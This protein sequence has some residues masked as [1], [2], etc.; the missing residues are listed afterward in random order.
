MLA[1]YALVFGLGL[2]PSVAWLIFFD[3]EESK[4][5]AP[6]ID[7]LYAF[8]LGSLTTFA[9]LVV[10]LGIARVMPVIGITPH[11]GYGVTIFAAVEEVLKFAAV[12]FLISRRRSFNEPLDAMVYLITVALGFAAVE[13]IASLINQ[14]G[15]GAAAMSARSIELVVLRFLGATLLH[16]VT[17]AVV[18]FHWAVGWVR[19]RL[20]WFHIFAGLVIASALHAIFNYLILTTGPAS[21]ALAFVAAIAFFVLVDFEELRTEE[22]AE[23]AAGVIFN[24]P[25]RD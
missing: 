21:W 5:Y 25:P 12:Y 11:D 14:G 16:S 19:K 6:F 7:L 13:N 22:E 15:L 23:E 1:Q 10:Q 18:G 24:G 2:L 3:L 17:S 9:A 4:R 20:V 8:I